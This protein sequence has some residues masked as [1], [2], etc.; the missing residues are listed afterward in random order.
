MHSHCGFLLKKNG[1]TAVCFPYSRFC[2]IIG[3]KEVFFVTKAFP[4]C[5]IALFFAAFLLLGLLTAA[6]YGASWDEMDE[7]DILRMN[8][9][10]YTRAFGMDESAFEKRASAFDGQLTISRL[11]PISES[12]EQ[13]H[14]I[15]AFYPMAGVVMSEE[16]TEAQRSESWHMWCWVVFTLGAFA[17]Y[18]A[19]RELGIS[20]S[21]ALLGPVF[22]LLS[23][24]FFA[25]GHF[26]NKDIALFS[27]VLCT[28]WLALRLMKK[29][30]FPNGLLF[31]LAGAFA[32][33]T[34]LA[35]LAVWGLCAL[36]VL[37]AQLI[38]R[39]MKGR[40]W[41]V[42]GVTAA[43]FFVFYALITPA[44]WVSPAAFVKYLVQN[45]MAFQRWQNALL[46]RGT[47]FELWH[48]SLPVYYLPYMIL[49][50][51]PVW[52][53]A[54]AAIG[55]VCA[56]VHVLCKKPE[57]LGLV[58]V[59]CLFVLP[60]GFAVMTRTHV[61]NGW[62]H[63]YFVYGPMLMLAV[64][65]VHAIKPQKRWLKNACALVLTACMAISCA[66]VISQHPYQQAYYQSIVQLRG[67]DF[68]EL[69]YW[70]VSA[71]DA[72]QRL[73]DETAGELTIRPAD[74]WTEDA[75]AKALLLLDEA[76]AQRFTACENAQYVLANPT[77]V[78]FSGFD[79]EGM[80]EAV[81]LTSYGQPIMR[82]YER[83]LKGE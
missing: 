70:N 51:T 53:T 49:S 75:L 50:T 19:L 18:A 65:G 78:N 22:L 61:Y 2:G 8:L 59:A 39:N 81:C 20:R 47:V 41:A 29:P 69:D 74:L 17:L 79:A 63:F 62:R 80:E 56:L 27:L 30:T 68:N 25:H 64:F 67:T 9:W 3:R 40:V 15:S 26:N 73:A 66:G 14:G 6:D 83:S 34:K 76:T 32:A 11:T 72:L 42:A 52:I 77:Y 54:L 46:F 36:F 7:M 12:I 35:G 10:E 13:D 28:L 24:Q 16:L 37:L 82:I 33:N 31:S 43:S 38:R 55:A 5:L 44:M 58:L 71:R 60:L 57:A 4:R 21:M 45:A 48:E 1:K 23:P